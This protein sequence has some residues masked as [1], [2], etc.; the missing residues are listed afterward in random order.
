MP[1]VRGFLRVVRRGHPDQGLPGGEG[2]V[3]PDYGL[4]EG[5]PDQGLPGWERPIDP[6]Y[7]V[8]GGRPG[9]FPVWGAGRP[10]DPGFGIPL[11]PIVDNGLPGDPPVVDNGL[12]VR[13]T[14][15]VDPGFGIPVRPGVWP[16]PPSPPGIWPPK[17][18]LYPSHPIYPGA[19]RPGQ[20]PAPQP[21]APG[22]PDQGLPSAPPG[23]DNTLPLPP[24]AVW[25]PLPPDIAG[26]ILAF[27]W[28]VGIG[29]RWIV[30]DPSLKPTHPIE[31]PEPP[32]AQP[33]RG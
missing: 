9:H 21:P 25:P 26:Q 15:P 8:G 27:A 28:L 7:G 24:G 1:F 31:M 13:P 6:G 14:Y 33:K 11:P 19:G 20:G 16:K 29:Y 32:T 22:R 4:E 10:V 2:P 23:V 18:P 3:D 17:P 5:H 12:P 30:I